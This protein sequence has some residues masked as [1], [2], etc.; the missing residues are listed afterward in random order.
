MLLKFCV[1]FNF[2]SKPNAQHTCEKCGKILAN[3]YSYRRHKK[4]CDKQQMRKTKL[5][6]CKFCRQTFLSYLKRYRHEKKCKDNSQ[7]FRNHNS[8]D[9]NEPV[10]STS[11]DQCPR[12][13]TCRRCKC[14]FS[15]SKLYNHRMMHHLQDENNS[16][17]SLPWTNGNGIQPS[18]NDDSTT[19]YE[20]QKT[21]IQH[22]HLILKQKRTDLTM[23]MT[24]VCLDV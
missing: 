3:A 24:C 14:K 6:T 22:R 11:H 20:L 5:T 4:T 15:P 19:D 18:Q 13:L 12:Q 17:Q 16:Y 1:M 7:T 2:S 10:L 21:Y 23:K 9:S 8:T